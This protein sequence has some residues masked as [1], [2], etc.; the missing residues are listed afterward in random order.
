MHMFQD[1]CV[2]REWQPCYVVCRV[3]TFAT[4]LFAYDAKYNIGHRPWHP[5]Q[6]DGYKGQGLRRV[7]LSPPLTNEHVTVISHAITVDTKA[8]KS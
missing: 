5:L 3:V 2:G 8:F 6:A 1:W 7:I 4:F